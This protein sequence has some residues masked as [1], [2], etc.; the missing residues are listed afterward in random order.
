MP[1]HNAKCECEWAGEVFFQPKAGIESVECPNCKKCRLRVDWSGP[2]RPHWERTWDDR[3]GVSHQHA[4]HPSLVKDYRKRL[5][6][7]SARAAQMLGDDG[8]VR[9]TKR[10]DM[11]HFNEVVRSCERQDED[12]KRKIGLL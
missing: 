2:V 3:T 6:A 10:S 8:Q 11:R 4:C 5:G 7:F 12:D 1:L 9:A